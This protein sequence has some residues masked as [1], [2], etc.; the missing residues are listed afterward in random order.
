MKFSLLLILSTLVCELNAQ[1]LDLTT[2]DSDPDKRTAKVGKDTF[3]EMLTAF[4]ENTCI[5][6]ITFLD[7]HDFAKCE[8]DPVII[9]QKINSVL[10]KVLQ[11]NDME[12]SPGDTLQ[13]LS[14][15][16]ETC[17]NCYTYQSK[18]SRLTYLISFDPS[19]LIISRSDRIFDK[20][21]YPSC[22]VGNYYSWD[23]TSAEQIDSTTYRITWKGQDTLSSTNSDDYETLS[24]NNEWL[25]KYIDNQWIYEKVY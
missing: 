7:N 16:S 18:H 14:H 19:S 21:F 4:R 15:Q 9:S 12:L 1:I 17:E 11:H 13:Y 6:H 20:A 5:G 25:L 3:D 23:K 2:R 8:S 22:M 10:I 24:Y